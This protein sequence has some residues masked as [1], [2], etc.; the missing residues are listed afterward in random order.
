MANK[1]SYLTKKAIIRKLP[2]GKYR[3]YS[4]DGK[5]L[6]TFDSREKAEKHEREVQYFKHQKSA[7]AYDWQDQEQQWKP[8]T[9]EDTNNDIGVSHTFPSETSQSIPESYEGEF[10]AFNPSAITPYTAS[11]ADFMGAL[12][13]TIREGSFEY[14]EGKNY[15]EGE[16]YWDKEDFSEDCEDSIIFKKMAH[17]LFKKFKGL[18]NL[19]IDDFPEI[20]QDSMIAYYEIEN[21]FTTPLAKNQIE[22]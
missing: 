15:L 22:K 12:M 3:L 2:D 19:N 16:V 14:D 1:R 6:G 5:N 20:D 10:T 18:R 13:N 17:W 21:A 8:N 7:A 11:P 9:M 4:H